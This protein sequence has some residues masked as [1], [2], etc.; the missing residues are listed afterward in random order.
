MTEL[1]F[2]P[3]RV[4]ELRRDADEALIVGFEVPAPLRARFEFQPG[5]HLGL[6]GRVDGKELRRSYSICAAPGEMLRIG[7]RRV[8]GGVFSNWLHEGLVIGQHLDVQAPQGRFG[9]VLAESASHTRALHVLGVAG[10]SGITPILSI[11]KT[12]LARDDTSRVTLLYGNRSAASTMFKEELEDLKNRYLARLSLHWVFSREPAPQPLS[13]GRLDAAK[14]H[15]FMRLVREVSQAFVCG[16]HTFNDEAEQALHAA[17]LAPERV[18][19]ERFG[20]PPALAEV[21]GAQPPSGEAARAVLSI[22][23]DG[24]TRSVEFGAGDQNIL[25]AAQRAGLDL[26][27][28][29]QSGVCATCRA[30]LI[31]GQVHMDRN[32][33]LEAADVAAGFVLTC[34]AWPLTDQV[35][36]SFDER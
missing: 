16:P 33:A 29:C 12:V 35:T 32:F 7:V 27:F 26:P 11:M 22:V 20:V 8:P 13:E 15:Q 14:L 4:G 10:G 3:L 28:S 5:Q 30:K 9:A 18:H 36:V 2:H 17:W 24:V 1:S 23:R 25:G 6:C 21:T 34:Q 19:V 31:A